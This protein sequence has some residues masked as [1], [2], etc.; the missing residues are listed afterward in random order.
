MD[1]LTI[2]HGDNTDLLPTL[3]PR[4][5]QCVV[6]SPPYY[7]LRDYGLSPTAW[8]EI[9]CQPMPG[10]PAVVIPAQTVCLGLE[11]TPEV[12]TAHLVHVFRLVREA[13]ADDGV[14]WLNLGDSYAGS[15]G[16]YGSR[17][18]KQRGERTSK[19][20]VRPAY[21]GD[22]GHTARPPTA[23]NLDVKPKNMLGIP[24]RVAF[25]LQADG[26]YL[27]SDVIWHKPN[28]MPESVKDRPTKDHEYV[29]LL[30]KSEKYYFN[31]GAIKE[32]ATERTGKAATFQRDSGKH[33]GVLGPNQQ[34]SQHRPNRKQD[35]I[36]K[37]RYT[38]FNDRY[39]HPATRNRR[40]CWVV[41]ANE[42]ED[43]MPEF[44]SISTK[45]LAEAHYAPMPEALVEPCVLSGSRPGDLVLDPFGGSGTT[46]R[47]AIQYQRRAI[48]MD[49]NPAYVEIQDKRT[50]NVQYAMEGA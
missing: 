31:Q 4:S 32:P 26:W 27:R 25:A 1:D 47:K 28:A 50:T 44:W 35:A 9:S 23:N 33:V 18:K 24:W 14:C 40:T 8:P 2:M 46:A 15:W 7:G 17:D 6:T 13:L 36:G 10:L 48:L 37:D 22:K 11:D 30:A 5:V 38:G 39:Q 42:V 20:W 12:Y 21:D 41:P 49:L 3:A 29:F 34:A 19:E 45:A 16:N 43:I